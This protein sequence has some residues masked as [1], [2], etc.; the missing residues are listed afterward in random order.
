MTV[1]E[2]IIELTLRYG[3]PAYLYQLPVLNSAIEELRA[4]LPDPHRL[5]YSMK[6]NPHPD[7]VAAIARQGVC[8]EV[9]SLKEINVAVESSK[10][11]LYTGPGKTHDSVTSALD[12]GVRRFSVE[13]VAER[14]RIGE[15]ASKRGLR[16]EI[17]VR[18]NV[19]DDARASWRMGSQASQ[20]GI[21]VGDITQ[22]RAAAASSNEVQFRGFQLFAASN[23]RDEAEV[24]SSICSSIRA[25]AEARRYVESSVFELDLGGGFPASFGVAPT[26][27]DWTGLS[28]AI[29]PTLDKYFPGWR[30]GEPL[31][32]FESGRAIAGPMGTLL[33]TVLDIKC[34]R[35][36]QFAVLDSGINHLAGMSG[37]G[38]AFLPRMAPEIVFRQDE[39]YRSVFE[40][41]LVG[42][43]CTPADVLVRQAHFG[44]LGIGD[45]LAF[46]SVGAY[47]LTAS[48]L[49][50]LS[51]NSPLEIVIDKSASVVSASRL[52][53]SR[54]S[55]RMR[56]SI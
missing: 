53:V 41:D 6:A 29:Q 37:T 38:R 16:V 17:L 14:E 54:S 23:I 4:A 2:E 30:R 46:K 13:S 35:G 47:G 19:R 24:A 31:V 36:R 26:H 39:A 51:H 27:R 34:T 28:N 44:D 20:F 12:A 21:D 9:S 11:V 40:G 52:A 56:R 43:L 18:L 10:N 22:L 49:G 48:L 5:Y 25:A 50:F 33:T 42:P 55:V 1:P 8:L 45:I 3:T 32:S 7:V 15:V